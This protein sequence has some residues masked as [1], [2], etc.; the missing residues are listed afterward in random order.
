MGRS[1]AYHGR[2]QWQSRKILSRKHAAQN[3]PCLP[4][5]GRCNAIR[6]TQD[7]GIPTLSAAG[8]SPLIS[9]QSCARAFEVLVFM[10]STLFARIE[11]LSLPASLEQESSEADPTLHTVRW[12]FYCC[13][14]SECK[15]L[16]HKT[17]SCSW[18]EPQRYYSVITSNLELSTTVLSR[19]NNAFLPDTIR[20]AH[21]IRGEG[22]IWAWTS[23]SCSAV[24]IGGIG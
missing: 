2:A 5:S 4:G 13:N 17:A 15:N 23:P 3:T 21:R 10:G 24:V 7:S 20:G 11:S 1:A 9:L 12:A 22:D 19:D 14:G 6:I 16:V 8:S 18:R